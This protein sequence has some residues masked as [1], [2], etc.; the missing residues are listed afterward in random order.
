MRKQ[1]EPEQIFY[2][3]IKTLIRNLLINNKNYSTG[4][5]QSVFDLK[6][7]TIERA[8]YVLE[9]MEKTKHLVIAPGGA[10]KHEE[11]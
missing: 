5:Y 7:D 11:V 1:Q 3:H 6:N 9:E 4:Y 2:E 8:K 10:F